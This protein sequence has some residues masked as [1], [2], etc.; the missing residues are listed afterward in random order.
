[1]EMHISRPILNKNKPIETQIA[2]LYRWADDTSD[3]LNLLIQA[4][5]RKE[6]ENA[7]T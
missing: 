1:M 6:N 2:E 7:E 5:S 3:K 4:L